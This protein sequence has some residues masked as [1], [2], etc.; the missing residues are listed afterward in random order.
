V[1]LKKE[2][3][4]YERIQYNKELK[5][6]LKDKPIVI[7]LSDLSTGGA[8]GILDSEKT[9]KVHYLQKSDHIAFELESKHS[10]IKFEGEITRVDF[11]DNKIYIGIS[12]T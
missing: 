11:K 10:Y 4:N 12:Y 5:V 9:E 2:K 1:T 6:N 3:R 7:V 8:G